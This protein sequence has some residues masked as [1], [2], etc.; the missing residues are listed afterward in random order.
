MFG[1]V[2][3]HCGGMANADKKV[4]LLRNKLQLAALIAEVYMMDKADAQAK[5]HAERETKKTLVLAA[6]VKLADKQ[7]DV[8]KLTH[9]AEIT[10]ILYV[11]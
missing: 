11:D 1:N 7:G 6:N 10:A 2:N 8:S 9:Q 4:N 3:S 5:K